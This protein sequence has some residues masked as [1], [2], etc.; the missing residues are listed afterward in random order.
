MADT[1]LSTI[2]VSEAYDRARDRF[3]QDNLRL[4]LGDE[5]ADGQRVALFVRC[6]R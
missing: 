1:K 6:V 2:S 4:H 3:L 5:I